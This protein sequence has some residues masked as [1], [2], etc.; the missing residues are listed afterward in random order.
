NTRVGPYEVQGLLATGGS[1]KVYR[2]IAPNGRR[3]ALKRFDTRLR[4]THSERFQK[5]AQIRIDHPNVIEVLDAGTDDAGGPYIVLELLDG[6][7]LSERLRR[8]P[9]LTSEEV[10]ALGLQ[11]CDG[12]A[13]AHRQGVV[14]RDLK[15]ENLYLCED[16]AL[17][18]LD[19]GIALVDT[20]PERIT[21]TGLVVGTPWYL[22]PEQ[23][24][25]EAK[26]DARADIWS[27]GVVLYEALAGKTP[28]ARGGMLA[29]VLAILREDFEPLQVA[30]PQ[31]PSSLAV[32][33]ERC[34]VK[35]RDYRWSRVG[36]VREA[37]SEVDLRDVRAVSPEQ[38]R[39]SIAAGERRVVAVMFADRAD[40]LERIC[41]AVEVQGGVFLPLYGR[42][43][44]GLFGSEAWEGDEL[45][46]AAR[47]ALAAR[48]YAQ[49]VSVAAGKASRHGGGISGEALSAAEEG[50]AVLEK[51]SGTEEPV[52]VI[53][54]RSA[55]LL[56]ENFAAEPFDVRY[57]RLRR[58]RRHTPVVP[59]FVSDAPATRDS[60]PPGPVS[61]LLGR[62]AELAQIE[63]ALATALEDRQA[64]A[65][66]V[67]GP[68]GIGKTRLR[69]EMERLLAASVP[70][71]TVFSA[72]A[73]P[74]GQSGAR[75]LL[76]SALMRHARVR[77]V[78]H[79]APR[80]DA[81]V[82]DEERV[83]AVW[84]MVRAA[85]EEPELVDETAP[86]LG[87]LLGVPMG[88]SPEL[89][90]ARADPQVMA[91]R[92][93]MS[94]RDYFSGCAARGPVVLSLEDIHW[95]DEASLDLLSDLLERLEEL[96]FLIF[97]TARPWLEEV[98][99]AFL[100]ERSAWRIEPGALRSN[101]GRSL[102]EATAGRKI[103]ADT[104]TAITERCGGNPLFI[105][106]MVTELVET[107]ALDRAGDV[108]LPLTVE[109]AIQSRLDHLPLLE[110]SLCKKASV[111]MRPFSVEE[112]EA[113]GVGDARILLDSLRRR[114]IVSVR[115]KSRVGADREYRFRI[116]L[117]SEV[118]YDLLDDDYR[119]S[120][121]R[122]AAKVLT[123]I[124][125]AGDEE[126]AVH[127]ERGGERGKAS[128]R[129]AR[130]ALTAASKGDGVSVIRC[131]DGALRLN[132]KAKHRFEVHMARADAYQFMGRFT[133][134]ESELT[135]AF[136]HAGMIPAQAR[137]FSER[138]GCFFRLG[139]VDE[140][141]AAASRA[142]E[143]CERARDRTQLS[144]A[145]SRL[146]VL[147]IYRGDFDA[148]DRCL[149]AASSV[150]EL[151]IHTRALLAAHR[152]QLANAVGGP[153]AR[154]EAYEEAIEAFSAAGDIRRTSR[155]YGNLA[156]AYNRLGA[157]HEAEP[158]L[159]K[160]L[161]GS[162]RA[163]DSSTAAY[164]LAN[165]A[166]CL[167]AQ[168]RLKE[169]GECL[170][171][172]SRLADQLGTVRL[173]VMVDTY[174]TEYRLQT[175]DYHRAGRL[176]LSAARRAAGVKAV[177]WCALALAKAA[178]GLLAIGKPR[179]ALVASGRAFEILRAAGTIEEGEIEVLSV[180]G[181]AQIDAG[182]P[183]SGAAI[184]REAEGR[185]REAAER[186]SDPTLAAMYRDAV[187]SHRR[188][189]E[190]LRSLEVS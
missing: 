181:L 42:R 133:D 35:Q 151:P 115:S 70:E 47:A 136:E 189:V 130:A 104:L 117:V 90:A 77:T 10:L 190:K 19:F 54:R 82:D 63:R 30:A 5:E 27:L 58:S 37:L 88:E 14:H 2:A 170:D 36:A 153:L 98:R 149:Q 144:L 15:P 91:D 111:L 100:S 141:T 122:I 120:L 59:H 46:R 21:T 66:L 97:S 139:R 13:A 9:A 75:T 180:H 171:E 165:L 43:A 182:D 101:E 3:V 67:V 109:A 72:R 55:R 48:A 112:L 125:K 113:I 143:L 22:S 172:A 85:I 23:A 71:A 40:D 78:E 137:V 33:I 17:K 158:R 80:I 148:A 29:T 175:R 41:A 155:N 69:E 187:P 186:I 50:C 178:R 24:R 162:Q 45:D 174:K 16:G 4:E 108:P 135:R 140:A 146:G 119:A 81:E 161:A 138:V 154:L 65:V 134:Q 145:Q 95:A 127:H 34:L 142:I 102:A 79:N 6:E 52:V 18:I 106:Q 74:L 51:N 86:F 89:V 105:E 38:P 167:L 64:T 84:S 1:G 62:A 123:K 49:R 157:F 60:I 177:S 150:A 39:P 31:V 131:S 68:T 87:E 28:F 185:V 83:A 132:L 20:D 61:T 183:A 126:L 103:A 94:I 173:R 184:L 56:G 128:Q 76:G 73:D 32:V 57:A 124:G 7:P 114:G 107:G 99:S 12:L 159:R 163:G 176:A 169:A 152:A 179:S 96:P 188:V 164:A 93:D 26:L 116:A 92:L 8:N 121:H 53:D 129:Y 118:A 11:L 44:V 25:G 166:Y 147:W 168:R 110:K 156:D 160:A